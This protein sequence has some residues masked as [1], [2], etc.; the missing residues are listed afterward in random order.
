MARSLRTVLLVIVAMSS[1]PTGAAVGGVSGSSLDGR[2]SFTWTP[3]V[4]KSVRADPS[5]AGLYVVEFR[6]GH[7]IRLSPHPVAIRA[8]VTTSGDLATFVFP[9]G[10]TGVAPGR[11]YT[12][13]W[14]IYRDRLTWAA[15]PGHARLGLFIKVPWTRVR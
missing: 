1:A 9:A 2:W 8:R 14:S 5:L 3:A 6:D 7:L 13:H 11:P 10:V 4:V 15:A 12:M